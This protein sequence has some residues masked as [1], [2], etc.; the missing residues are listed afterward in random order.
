METT[1]NTDL[2]EEK[3]TLFITLYAKA[4]DYQS[5]RSILH[6]KKADEILRTVNIDLKKYNGFGNSVT[7]VRARQFDEWIR[8]F[9][10]KLRNAV[11]LNLGCGLDTR[12]TRINPSPSVT[13]YDIDYPEVI[14]LRKSFYRESETYRMLSSSVTDGA[15]LIGIPTGRPT[16][17]IAEGLVEY[18]AP[19]QVRTLLHRL[20]GHFRHGQIIFDVMNSFAVNAGKK[21]LKAS[22]GAVHKWAVDDIEEVDRLNFSLKRMDALPIFHSQYTRQLPRGLRFMIS[23][24]SVFSSYRNLM[25]LLRY[26]F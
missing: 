22:T 6:D 25:R 15:W 21:K 9:I 4:L 3:E 17:I 1:G 8:E 13:W 26:Q 19:D 12:V 20:T 11:V 2:K 23:V 24:F 14:A 18:L 10:G 5:K 16:L 7:V